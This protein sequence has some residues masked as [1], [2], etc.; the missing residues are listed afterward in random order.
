MRIYE[1]RP[2]VQGL[3]VRYDDHQLEADRASDA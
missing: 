1:A 2:V 3:L